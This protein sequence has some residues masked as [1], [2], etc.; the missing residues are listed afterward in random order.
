MLVLKQNSAIVKQIWE[1]NWQIRFPSCS[2]FRILPMFMCTVPLQE[3]RTSHELKFTDQEALFQDT[4]QGT[5]GQQNTSEGTPL[6]LCPSIC[7]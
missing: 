2:L 7:G 3:H 1:T 5:S 6:A 4:S